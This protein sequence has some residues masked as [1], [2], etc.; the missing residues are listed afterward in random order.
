MS[1]K[2]VFITV[3]LGTWEEWEMSIQ[4]WSENPKG[5]YELKK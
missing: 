2:V 3:E 1:M 4:F 5:V